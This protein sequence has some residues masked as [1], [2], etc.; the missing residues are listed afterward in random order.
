MKKLIA[1]ILCLVCVA[2]LCF[3]GC[4]LP[5]TNTGDNADNTT[6]AA[7]DDLSKLNGKTPQELFTSAQETLKGYTRFKSEAKQI[8]KMDMDGSTVAMN[9][10]VV[11]ILDGQNSYMK[12]ETSMLGET[13]ITME[14]YYVDGV[15]YNVLNK[16]KAELPWETYVTDYLGGDPTENMLLNIPE[17][18]FKD[19]KFEQKENSEN[20]CLVF[21]ISGEKYE[22]LIAKTG[23]SEDADISDVIYTIEFDKDGNLLCVYTDYSMNVSGVAATC[24]SVSTIIT[25]GVDAVTAPA[26]ADSYQ[27]GTLPQ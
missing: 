24:S 23:L 27:T 7:E 17:D 19:I 18:W 4:E 8:I 2:S 9:Q 22:E 16:V 6:A 1:I 26:D 11:S 15:V 14:G 5:N 20:F 25:E 12:A 3:V 21:N 13:Q 10:T